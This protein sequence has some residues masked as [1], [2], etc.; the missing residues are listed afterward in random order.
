MGFSAIN[1]RPSLGDNGLSCQRLRLG[2]FKPLD[3]RLLWDA[4]SMGRCNRRAK[5]A[6]KHE[7][8]N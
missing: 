7:L 8:L 4:V 2:E 3:F 5:A 6:I 1:E